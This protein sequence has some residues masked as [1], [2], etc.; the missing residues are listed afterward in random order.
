M[1][2]AGTGSLPPSPPPAPCTTSQEDREAYVQRIATRFL[3]FGSHHL[4]LSPRD[5]VMIDEWWSSHIPSRVVM[6]GLD[7]AF[8]ARLRRPRSRKIP[9]RN[10]SFAAR[11]V[12]KSWEDY[13]ELNT[14]ARRQ[15]ASRSQRV[16]GEAGERL[17][18]ALTTAVARARSR[19]HHDLAMLL[20]EVLG[21]LE[22]GLNRQSIFEIEDF[23]EEA[24]AGISPVLLGAVGPTAIARARERARR[25]LADYTSDPNFETYVETMAISVLRD[26]YPLPVLTVL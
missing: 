20:G 15:K 19:G 13:R 7:R 11:S 8:L 10:L 3:R 6:F 17:R 16:E 26:E 9:P 5:Y 23:L 2:R 18:E 14:G 4:F 1:P 22:H 24:W 21:N 12:K 25:E